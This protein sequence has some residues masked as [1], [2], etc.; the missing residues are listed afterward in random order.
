MT[1]EDALFFEEKA[2]ELVVMASNIKD[3]NEN[4]N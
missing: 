3:R 1:S 4:F 2:K